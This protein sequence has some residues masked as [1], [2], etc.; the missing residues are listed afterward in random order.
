L[1]ARGK[2]ELKDETKHIKIY[3]KKRSSSVPQK[4]IQEIPFHFVSA[5]H[6]LKLICGTLSIFQYRHGAEKNK[7]V[8]AIALIIP[9]SSR[10]EPVMK[11]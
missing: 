11:N 9:H 3:E 7:S 10:E 8:R 5:A 1:K 6:K 4:Q 2:N